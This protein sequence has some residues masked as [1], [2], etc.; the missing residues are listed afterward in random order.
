MAKKIIRNLFEE[1]GIDNPLALNNCPIKL[2]A[3]NR[4]NILALG[5]VGTTVLLGLRL[6]GGD[7]ISS[8]GIYDLNFNNL[9]RLEME[10]N[11]IRIPFEGNDN[12]MPGV[13]VI[14]EDK[15]F[16]CD[17]L[18]FCASKGVPEIGAE[19][20]VRMVQLSANSKIIS[21]YGNMAR[22]AEFE[23]FIAVV[24]DP[25]DPLCKALLQASELKPS[26]IQG[27]GLGVMNA[28]ALYYAEKDSRFA[29]YIT[30]G[31]AY[32]PHGDDLIIANSIKNYDDI[33][34]KELTELTIN[35]N[36]K[37]R[38]LGYKPYIAPA[39]SS[40]AISILMTLRGQWHYSS[41]YFGD[42][43]KGA[44][45]GIRNI[46]NGIGPEYE[47]IAVDEKLFQRIIKSYINLCIL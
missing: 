14:S 42:G 45:L 4:V 7:V 44:F 22:E 11:Q 41:L 27:Y 1:V 30:D 3:K 28:R 13:E 38:D 40:A 29:S 17:M 9:K 15:L 31:R 8:I 25:V 20:D 5:D 16:D 36:I 34:S 33:I 23:G 10:I 24:S 6:M 46:M 39:I 43:T 35:C 26:Q 2:N 18:I 37:V 19:G 47:E 32:G 21:H 12:S